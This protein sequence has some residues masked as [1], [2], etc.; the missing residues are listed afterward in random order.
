MWWTQD[1][2][3]NFYEFFSAARVARRHS[4]T[5]GK[6]DQNSD[7]SDVFP[8]FFRLLNKTWPCPTRITKLG[9][10]G[11]E[12]PEK[13]SP[14]TALGGRMQMSSSKLEYSKKFQNKFSDT[15][16]VDSF[17]MNLMASTDDVTRWSHLPEITQR[18]S[19]E[20]ITSSGW[21][22][23]R[24]GVD[25]RTCSKRNKTKGAWPC[26]LELLLPPKV[27]E[28]LS[29]GKV[30]TENGVAHQATR[31]THLLITG[32]DNHFFL[33]KG[34]K[35]VTHFLIAR[36]LYL[37]KDAALGPRY[38]Q[39]NRP[40]QVKCI[41]CEIDDRHATYRPYSP[42]FLGSMSLF[43]AANYPVSKFV[44]TCSFYLFI[45]V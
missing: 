7:K 23:P 30:F 18:Q 10:N 34:G 25:E 37:N 43:L 45:F 27:K 6:F 9:A 38:Q 33:K 44:A 31:V 21:H 40:A 42:P 32:R 4:K 19:I 5:S 11:P 16:T 17:Q 3:V 26:L 14:S 35:N 29:A 28:T 15:A 1:I 24:W 41:P 36:F 12:I 2:P 22:L 8:S 39:V 20:W 13:T